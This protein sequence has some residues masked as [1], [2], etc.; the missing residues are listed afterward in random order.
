MLIGY[1]FIYITI[2][3]LLPNVVFALGEELGWRGYLVPELSKWVGFRGAAVAS[4]VVWAAWHLPGVLS[5]AYGAAGTPKAYRIACFVTMVITTAIALA[6]LRMKSGSVWPVA[7]A[8]ATHN[9]VI[10]AFFDALTADTGHTPYF[11]GEFGV[12]MLPFMSLIAWYCLTRVPE[13]RHATDSTVVSF[14]AAIAVESAS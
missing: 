12:A 9:G 4:G 14:P 8:H 5:G 11:I 10:Q 1:A 13:T 2:I 7:I 6:W 3:N